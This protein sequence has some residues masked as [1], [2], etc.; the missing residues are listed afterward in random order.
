MNAV[1]SSLVESDNAFDSSCNLIQLPTA[2]PGYHTKLIPSTP[3]HPIRESINYAQ[4]LFE[5][6]EPWRHERACKVLEKILELQEKDPTSIWFGL[7]GWFL[8]EPPKEMAPADWNWADFIGSRLAE[9][10]A[11]FSNLLSPRL[12]KESRAALDRAAWCIFRRNVRT[13]YTNICAM[14]A[15]VCLAAGELL[16]EPRLFSYGLDRLRNLRKRLEFDGGF[17]EYNSSTYTLVALIEFERIL[18]L[19]YNSEARAEAEMLLHHTWRLISSQFHPGTGQWAGPACRSY[20]SWLDEPR[21]QFLEE[22][23]GFN[24]EHRSGPKITFFA[25]AFSSSHPQPCPE[26]FRERFRALPSNS[27]VFKNCWVRDE[28]GT[29][30][31]VST[32]WFT[33]DATLG[34]MSRESAWGQRRVVLGY[35]RTTEDLAIRLRLRVLHDGRDFAS[36]FVWNDQSDS[37]VLTGVHFVTGEGDWHPALDVPT[38]GVFPMRDLRLRYEVEGHGLSLDQ[39]S[40]NVFVFSAGSCRAA[41]HAGPGWFDGEQIRGWEMGG[42][43]DLKWVDFVFYS[44]PVRGFHPGTVG[45]TNVSVALELLAAAETLTTSPLESSKNDTHRKFKWKCDRALEVRIPLRGS[46]RPRP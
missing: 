39:T 32:T 12:L 3:S 40:E 4:M 37:R 18:G 16:P 19:I 1:A 38:D 13:D 17:T 45:E 14:G 36:G 22:R 33:E 46:K 42:E 20:N 10:I 8:E 44:G 26:E 29:P 27:Y 21:W 2:T 6:P 41:V 25:D 7:W 28:K 23:L 31:Q 30:A 43:G 15:A 9:I 35:W 5:T 34:S 24:L 11:R